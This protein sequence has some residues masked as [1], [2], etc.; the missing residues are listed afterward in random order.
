MGQPLLRTVDIRSRSLGL[1]SWD[2]ALPIPWDLTRR[3]ALTEPTDPRD[4]KQC[5][6]VVVGRVELRYI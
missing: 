6:I 3:V 1:C 5:R 2:F 4:V